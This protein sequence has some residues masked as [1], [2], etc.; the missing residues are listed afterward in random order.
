MGDEILYWKKKKGTQISVKVAKRSKKGR[1]D[2]PVYRT[3]IDVRDPK[4]LAQMLEDLKIMFN[5]PIDKAVKEMKKEKS[6]F[7]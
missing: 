7:W 2:D 1:F 5:A 4:Q 6:P 3:S